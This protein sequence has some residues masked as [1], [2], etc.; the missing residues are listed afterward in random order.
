MQ[1]EELKKAQEFMAQCTFE[2]WRPMRQKQEIKL[3]IWITICSWGT[4]PPIPA[5]D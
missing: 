5:E 2:S 4:S 3:E 1:V